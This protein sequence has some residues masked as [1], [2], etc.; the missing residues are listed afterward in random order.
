MTPPAE[1]CTFHT[2]A[3][4]LAARTRNTP[5][6]TEFSARYCSAIRCLRSPA[7]QK[8]TGTPFAAAQGW[9]H[10]A[11]VLRRVAGGG[12]TQAWE[13]L[14]PAAKKFPK[15]PVI[16]YN[17]AC[18]ACQLLQPDLAREWLRRALLVGD[19]EVLKKMALADDDLQPL[20]QEIK[21]LS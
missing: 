10:R 8:I 9:L 14:L 7:V 6:D 3:G 20:W 16:A 19:K 4:A 18:Y 5:G 15:E 13:A 11:Y 21:E 2:L 12:L 1:R 17:L